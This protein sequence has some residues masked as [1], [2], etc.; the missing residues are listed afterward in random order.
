[1]TWENTAPWNQT[2]FLCW[3]SLAAS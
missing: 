2:T 1:M 3:N